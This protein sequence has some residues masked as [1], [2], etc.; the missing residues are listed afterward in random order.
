MMDNDTAGIV[1]LVGLLGVF[2]SCF[3][4]GFAEQVGRRRVLVSVGACA[5]VLSALI[6]SVGVMATAE[7]GWQR[8]LPSF[9]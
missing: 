2:I 1:R 4:W 9:P 5:A 3:L 7:S 6:Y 8:Y